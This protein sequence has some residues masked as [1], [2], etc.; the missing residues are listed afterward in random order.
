LATARKLPSGTW[1]TRAYAG[2]NP[3]ASRHY[4][5]YTADTKAASER[6]ALDAVKEWQDSC[7]MSVKQHTITFEQASSQYL[8]DRK[9]V[10]SPSTT[11]AYIIM[12]RNHM[13]SIKNTKVQDIRSIDLQK[14]VDI[15]SK[16][17]SPKYVR[18]LYSL[19]LSII[20]SV[21]ED[22][23]FKVILP[24]RKKFVYEDANDLD[25]QRLMIAAQGSRLETA[26]GIASFT[27]MRRSEIAALKREDL[28]TQS[29]VIHVRRAMVP[30][31]DDNGKE[32]WA[33]KGTKNT[34][35]ERDIDISP[36]EMEFILSRDSG[37]EYI[38]GVLPDTIT[39]EFDEYK[40][41]LGL[42]IRFHDLRSY[43][44][45]I[46]HLLGIPDKLIIKR[47]GHATPY[48]MNRVYN[49][50]TKDRVR[51][52]SEVVYSHFDSMLKSADST[53]SQTTN[54]EQMHHENAPQNEKI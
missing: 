5:S 12:L 9:N 49:R 3:D 14:E 23:R 33:I 7:G 16:T 13:Q 18:N 34:D 48:V 20:C 40:K 39:T 15:D 38:L 47:T 11:R 6:G 25:I 52:A 10:L 41:K 29:N 8:S 46:M 44:V 36:Y 45:S 54:P 30:A 28:D 24:Q 32:T 43:N 27:G 42:K 21:I 51:K 35:S 17:L 2:L 31:L 4:V 37:K 1:R 19:V 53:T 50:A 22:A 26:V